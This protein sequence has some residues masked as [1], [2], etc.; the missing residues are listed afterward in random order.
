[1]SKSHK[2]RPPSGAEP[3]VVGFV[4]LGCAKNLVDSEKML[5]QIA[6]SGA[7]VSGDESVADT[8]VVNTCGFLESAR[9]EALAVI[10]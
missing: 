4:S 2:R 8:M 6:E 3:P 5:G 9:Q 1:M 7:V 10:G